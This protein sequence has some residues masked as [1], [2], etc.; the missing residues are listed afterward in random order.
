MPDIEYTVP[1]D[2]RRRVRAIGWQLNVIEIVRS[3]VE[4]VGVGVTRQERQAMGRPL[5]KGHLQAVVVG[6]VQVRQAVDLPQVRE[7]AKERP[8]RLPVALDCIAAA[9]EE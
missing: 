9:A 6:L 2:S 3:G 1:V 7:L 8:L 4:G 5:G